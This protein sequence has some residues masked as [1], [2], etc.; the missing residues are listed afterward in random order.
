M[1]KY[2]IRIV[3]PK[4]DYGRIKWL[5][6]ELNGRGIRPVKS[7]STMLFENRRD[8]DVLEAVYVLELDIEEK[9][10]LSKRLASSL[11]KSLGFFLIYKFKD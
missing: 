6:E 10:R 9:K 4:R 5:I 1:A 7:S 11:S 3:I 2:V 8:L